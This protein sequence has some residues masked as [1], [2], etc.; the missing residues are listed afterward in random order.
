MNRQNTNQ[1]TPLHRASLFGKLEIA[2]L[3]LDHGANVGA[4]DEFG[5]TPLHDVSHGVYS[6]EEAG[7]G[8]ARLLLER[9]ADM[10]AKTRSG[11]TPL[12]FVSNRDP[13]LAQLLRE[14][15]A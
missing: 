14:D 3:L 8:V 11:E 10:N 2:R 7:I 5:R 9:G 1:S 4:K 13:K 12:D 6:P 15:G